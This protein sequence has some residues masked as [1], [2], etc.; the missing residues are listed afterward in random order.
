MKV[1]I[2]SDNRELILRIMQDQLGQEAK[3]HPLPAFSFTIGPYT[4]TR[5]NW[6]GS[7]C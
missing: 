5:E 6:H 7:P 3:Y 1:Q 2:T 4:L